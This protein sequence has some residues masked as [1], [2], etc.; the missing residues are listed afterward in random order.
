MEKLMEWKFQNVLKATA[1]SI[2]NDTKEDNSVR[3]E[4]MKIVETLKKVVDN[5]DEIEPELQKIFA[6][7]KW[8]ELEEK[9]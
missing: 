9:Q 4:R 3:K 2:V 1:E 6:N 5:Y 8:N 7:K